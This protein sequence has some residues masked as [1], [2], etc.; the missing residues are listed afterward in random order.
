MLHGF[1][2]APVCLELDLDSYDGPWTH[3][4]RFR[5]RRGW[6]MVANTVMTTPGGEHELGIVVGCDEWGEAIP[7]WRAA[8]LLECACSLPQPC[9]EYAPAVLEAIAQRE[10]R[11]VK[12]RWLREN[13]RELLTLAQAVEA[14]V[15]AEEHRTSDLIDRTLADVGD[16]RRR[17]RSPLLT[18]DNRVAIDEAIA[19]LEIGVEAAL[20]NLELERGRIRAEA[21][22]KERQLLKHAAVKVEIEPAYVVSWHD[23]APAFAGAADHTADFDWRPPRV[24]FTYEATRRNA[25]WRDRAAGRTDPRAARGGMAVRAR[26]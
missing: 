13:N 21:G 5:N 17:R 22:E 19:S 20:H 3:V 1:G 26:R 8:H 7:G 24:E 16:L 6:L 15:A 25:W 2:Q 11:E 12:L 14:A 4:D 9:D 23:G 10:A 18:A